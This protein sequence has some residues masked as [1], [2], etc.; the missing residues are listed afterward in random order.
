MNWSINVGGCCCLASSRIVWRAPSSRSVS[1][2]RAHVLRRNVVA[3]DSFA[4]PGSE[5]KRSLS[6][7]DF[8]AQLL[9]PYSSCFKCPMGKLPP[10]PTQA[11]LPG[12]ATSSV[13]SKSEKVL[14]PKKRNDAMIC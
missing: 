14:I 5:F 3:D 10:S 9:P 12:S 2:S 6:L 13:S 1:R 7:N 4:T 8:A 11:R